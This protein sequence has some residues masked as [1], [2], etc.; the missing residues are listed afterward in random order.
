MAKFKPEA[1]LKLA[2]TL[3]ANA[4]EAS[5]RTSL[6]RAYYALFLTAR[7]MAAVTS[8]RADAHAKTQQFFQHSGEKHLAEGLFLLRELRN[9]ADYDTAFKPDRDTVEDTIAFAQAMRLS[10]NRMRSLSLS[11][12]G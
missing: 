5:L 10:L 3:S 7:S 2:E 8:R 11:A 1:F 12:I 6:S 4:D 9:A